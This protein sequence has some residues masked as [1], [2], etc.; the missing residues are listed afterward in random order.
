MAVKVQTVHIDA[1][2]G[3]DAIDIAKAI[4][5]SRALQQKHKYGQRTF[6]HHK[7]LQ[8]LN[9][10]VTRAYDALLK[11]MVRELLRYVA[12]NIIH[13][14]LK[15]ADDGTYGFVAD[16]EWP[17]DPMIGKQIEDGDRESPFSPMRFQMGRPLWLLT[18]QQ[19]ERIKKI[20]RDY[21]LAFAVGV[22]GPDSIPDGEVQRLIDA[23]VIPQD[24][25]YVFQPGPNERP[26]DAMRMTDTAYLYG[27]EMPDARK[28]VQDMSLPD[29]ANRKEP[30]LSSREQQAMAWARHNA[31]EYIRGAGDKL[32]LETGQ[33]I[34]NADAEQRRRYI[35]VVRDK[36]DE[37]LDR[38]E[39]W[40]KLASEIG[41][42]TKDWSRDMGRLA[43]TEKQWA[44]QEGTAHG[45][46]KDGEDPEDIRVSKRPNPDACPDCVRLHLTAGQGSPPKIFKLSEL[47]ENGTNVGLKRHDWKAVV[48][49]VHP[50]CFLPGTMISM[51]GVFVRPI[52]RIEPGDLVVTHANRLRA[53]Q[54]LS[55]RD[56]RG[57][58][59]VLAIGNEALYLT[60]EHPLLTSRG[61][62]TAQAIEAGDDL[63]QIHE[64]LLS[65]AKAK[66]GPS[67]HQEETF[68]AYVLT[69]L[70]RAGVP[71]GINF[72][73]DSE[74][75]KSNV[76]VE[77]P[78]REL[79]HTLVSGFMERMNRQALIS[80]DYRILLA[81]LRRLDLLGYRA[82]LSTDSG[83][84]CLREAL[85][86]FRVAAARHDESLLAKGSDRDTDFDQARRDCAAGCFEA[87]SQFLDAIPSHDVA[88]GDFAG[89]EVESLGHDVAYHAVPV[90][91]ISRELYAGP[92]FNFSVEED[93]SY[94]A[95]GCVA[96]NCACELV[97]VPRGWGYNEEGTMVPDIMRRGDHFEDDLRK[98][99]MTYGDAVPA[100]MCIVRIGD[101]KMRAIV[102]SVVASAPPE[103]FNKDVGV[104]LI[105][106][107]TPRAQNPL[108][109]HDFAYWT[110]NEIR[111]M[112]TLPIT[113]VPRVI[114]HELGHSLNVHLM[115]KFGGV[116]AVRKWHDAL[117]AVSKREG[118]VSDYANREPIENAAEVTRMY[119]FERR[120]LMVKW[121]LQFAFCHRDYRDIWKRK[122]DA[123]AIRQEADAEDKAVRE[124]GGN[125]A[126]AVREGVGG[127][128][129]PGD[130]GDSASRRTPRALG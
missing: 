111:I 125:G 18:P 46:V 29:F 98:S 63:L 57:E 119:I 5:D 89:G 2:K 28:D 96:H 74:V 109:E 44:M 19:L 79:W 92:V 58:L 41:H 8:Q 7:P 62:L 110:G 15:K 45:L 30:K 104:T 93:E 120:D 113:R 76:R 66:G 80:T 83:M 13:A 16:V 67:E 75:G 115:R 117:W 82:W 97:E 25:A 34:R 107:D 14:P 121:P 108:E 42:A 130:D 81:S 26:P 61:W 33:N 84:S 11:K 69:A 23:G 72:D 106:T 114:R 85:S 105:T 100:N 101:P 35:G 124:S 22:L 20:I 12:E 37:N 129:V 77:R 102:E 43:A 60:P 54:R 68:L 38:R 32:I 95:N 128:R 47:Q 48:G 127:K 116:E 99:H 73:D 40:R 122:K 86:I 55:Q 36:V 70:A 21:H 52:E 88:L 90:T 103:I 112:Q 91:S 64:P 49:T 87:I 39:T 56:F 27:R 31:A 24:L 9:A 10:A 3:M 65:Y 123:R 6:Q 118:W 1:P 59:V 51:D 71:V 94:I 78:Y 50:W 17:D 53:V 4:V 126:G